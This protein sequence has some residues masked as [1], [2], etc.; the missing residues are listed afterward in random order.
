MTTIGDKV[1]HVKRA[2]QTRNHA[3]H[4]PGCTSQVP[5]ALWGCTRHWYRIPAD[6]RSKIWRAYRVGQEQDGRP[7]A[8]YLEVAREIQ[9][10]I[11]KH[12]GAP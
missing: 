3:C 6:L 11:R 8:R 2:G 4:W 1:A 7:S 10:W 5:P 9:D 12:G